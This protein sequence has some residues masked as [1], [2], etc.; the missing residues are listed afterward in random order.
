[1]PNRSSEKGDRS[2]RT[3]VNML[4]VMGYAVM[5]APSSGSATDHELPDMVASR[6]IPDETDDPWSGEAFVLVAEHKRS[7]DDRIYLGKGEVE[8]LRWFAYMFGGV[9][10]VV[11]RWDQDTTHYAFHIGDLGHDEDR[12]E[13]SRYRAHR[14]NR[15]DAWVAFGESVLDDEDDEED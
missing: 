14:D 4:Y 13:E 8:A 7:A 6:F 11:C 9:P 3:F 1:M 12:I 15:D 10:I 5:R 2:E